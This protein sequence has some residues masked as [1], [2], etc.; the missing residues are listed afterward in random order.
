MNPS[1]LKI[2]LELI[3]PSIFILLGLLVLIRKK[4]SIIEYR[5]YL[6][7]FILFL[8]S[9]S[10]HIP[11]TFDVYSIVIPLSLILLGGCTIYF[12]KGY[13][14]FA[15]NGNDFYKVL[16]EYLNQNNYEYEQTPGSIKI[17]EPLLEIIVD[18]GAIAINGHI[19][20]KNQ[21]NVG[22]FNKI[23]TDLKDKKIKIAPL[24]PIAY[25]ALGVLV[26]CINIYRYSL[27]N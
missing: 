18:P 19:K 22:A 25:I 7:F 9:I 20:L 26:I 14:V 27:M 6:F 11:F 2:I 5:Y 1:P 17:N 10:I 4:P 13:Y 15:A 21:E 8:T 16:I 3:F 23:I 24:T 12:K